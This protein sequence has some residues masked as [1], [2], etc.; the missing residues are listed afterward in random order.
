VIDLHAHVL[1]GVD[2]GAR[3][4]EEA[5]E[6]LAAAA[7]DGTRTVCAT[8]H[9]HGP[10]Y[11]VPRER[12]EAAWETLGRAAAAAGIPVELRL[13]SEVWYR[14][15]LADLAREGRLAPL[16]VAGK[17]YLLVEFPPTHVPPEAEETYFRLRLEGYT[18]VVAHPE[19]NPGFWEDPGRVERLREQGAL[20]QVTAGSLTGMFRAEARRCAKDLLKRGA[21]DL[22]ASDCHRV[23]RR[24]P[25]LSEAAREVV[26][27]A[28]A[29]AAD[30][31]TVGV[32]SAILTGEPAPGAA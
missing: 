30:R 29:E 7:R 25:G 20:V 31:L 11:D 17:R 6:M 22:L 5:L 23:D 8:P 1:P 4:L 9:A 21:V 19:R 24:P 27:L 16:A 26:R 32:P 12:A 14:P 13:A 28:G 2:D 10:G 18:P 3:D 15:D